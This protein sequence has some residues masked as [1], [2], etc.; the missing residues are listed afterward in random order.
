MKKNMVYSIISLI[1]I[2]LAIIFVLV[3]IFVKDSGFLDMSIL[4]RVHAVILALVCFALAVF[5][6]TRLK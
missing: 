6:W 4:I 1:L 2:I 3:A 5:L